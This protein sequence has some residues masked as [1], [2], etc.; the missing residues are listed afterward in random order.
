MGDE[1]T[2]MFADIA[3]FT[4]LTEAHGD[5]E[6]ADLALEFCRRVSRQLG[7]EDGEVVKTIGDAVMVRLTS[8]GR[9]IRLGVAIVEDLMSEHG[10]PTVRVGMHSGPA[11]RRGGDYFGTTVN[12]AARIAAAAAGGEVLISETVRQLGAAA[13]SDVAVTA[14][15]EA[16]FRN[17][18]APVALYAVHRAHEPGRRQHPLDPVCRM[19]VVPGREARRVTHGDTIH[20]FCSELCADRF[21]AAP[22][23]YVGSMRAT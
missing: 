13:L 14:R 10:Q 16:R 5:D 15:G 22:G 18:A 6:A 3:G 1:S 21:S 17:V 7:P 12:L 11:T 4:A 20:F 9:A 8:A 2:F 19:A 23:D